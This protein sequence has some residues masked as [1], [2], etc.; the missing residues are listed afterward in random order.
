MFPPVASIRNWYDKYDGAPPVILAESVC[1]IIV[2]QLELVS[3]V[4]HPN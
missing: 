1:T 3:A 4:V 2:L